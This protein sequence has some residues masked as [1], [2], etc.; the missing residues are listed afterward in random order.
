[1]K[2]LLT[3]FILLS[4]MIA[5]SWAKTHQ[6]QDQAALNAIY[7]QYATA[8]AALDAEQ[9]KSVYA[10][11][12]TYV[13]E[14][15][16]IGIIKGLDEVLAL[17][18]KFFDRVKK[19]RATLEVDFR[20]V[21]RQRHGNEVTDI[22]YYM[23]RFHPPKDTEEPISEFAGKLV[24]VLKKADQTTNQWQ[25][26]LDVSNRAEPKLYYDAT[27]KPNWY[28]GEQFSPIKAPINP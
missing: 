27:P 3:A 8:F 10:K 5:P 22:C 25:V 24:M 18:Q 17:Y 21:D 28:Y 16:S 19:R 13:P 20:V 1:M 2:F 15:P 26:V 4:L 9:L 11:N 23:V 6:E 12:A 7:R 14:Q